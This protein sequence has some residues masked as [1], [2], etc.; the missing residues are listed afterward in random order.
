MRRVA[1]ILEPGVDWRAALL[2]CARSIAAG[3]GAGSLTISEPWTYLGTWTSRPETYKPHEIDILID[4]GR[5]INSD[6]MMAAI[7]R[8][9]AQELE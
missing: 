5:N 1:L 7:V 4:P 9:H 3:Y 6:Y 2:D 8:R